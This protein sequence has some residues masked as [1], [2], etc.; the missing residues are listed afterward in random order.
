MYQIYQVYQVQDSFTCLLHAKQLT[1]TG[2]NS[3]QVTF[4][5][6]YIAIPAPLLF[7]CGNSFFFL[8]GCGNPESCVLCH[9]LEFP[10]EIETQLPTVV[11]GLMVNPVST[12]FLPCFSSLHLY[13]YSST[14]HIHS[15]PYMGVCFWGNHYYLILNSHWV[16]FLFFFRSV[17]YQRN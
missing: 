17:I 10:H 7:G 15:N 11:A 14:S 16:F 2:T 13:R 5:S 1:L 6:C 3:L 12:P 8:R 9:F 4:T